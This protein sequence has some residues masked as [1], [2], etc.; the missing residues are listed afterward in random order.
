[1]SDPEWA[2]EEEVEE[3]RDEELGPPPEPAPEPEDDD[4]D[5]E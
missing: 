3:R 4:D 5:D 2:S 1:M